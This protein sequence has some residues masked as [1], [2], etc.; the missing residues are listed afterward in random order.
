MSSS[1]D[2]QIAN[3]P[4]RRRPSRVAFAA[5]VATLALAASLAAMAMAAGSATTVSSTSS[6]KLAERI[7]INSRG[8]TLYVLTPET[9]HHLLCKSSACFA[10]WPPLTVSS[11]KVKLKAGSGVNGKLGILRR[12]NGMLQVTLRGLPLYTYAGDSSAG[13]TNGQGIR[14]FG[15][16]WHA[17]T[18]SAGTSSAQSAPT[19]SA[20]SSSGSSGGY[21]EP[22]TGA[23]P[24]T[25]TPTSTTPTTTTPTYP[26]TPPSKEEPAW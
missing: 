19:S 21:N 11:T 8:R 5:A 1:N 26:S 13:Q 7:V 20:P 22:T 16:V 24:T 9:T 12:S 2:R 4:R 23:A 18:A 6:S 17:M 3:S 14:S 15:G 10:V 25:T